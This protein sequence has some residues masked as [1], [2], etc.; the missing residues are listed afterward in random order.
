MLCS[1]GAH[2]VTFYSECTAKAITHRVGK[3]REAAAKLGLADGSTASSNP[4]TPASSAKKRARR[5][6]SSIS[7]AAEGNG[8]DDDHE[9]P[10]PIK[11]T[12]SGK[13]QAPAIAAAN[14][15]EKDGDENK[16]VTEANDETEEENISGDG[17]EDILVKTEV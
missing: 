12:K 16:A 17:T 6:D 3:F 4:T 7:R 15:N 14:T 9:T 1:R 10:S 13:K 11:K 8:S 2:I 5:Q